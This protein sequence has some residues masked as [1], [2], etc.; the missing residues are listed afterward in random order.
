M[1]LTI[2]A[3]ILI[4]GVLVFV[5][6]LGHFLAAKRSGLTVHEFGFGF[7]PRVFGIRRG[8]T[9]YSINWIPIGGFVKIKGE[10]G[11]E[12]ASTDSFASLSWFR[13]VFILLSGV[14]MNI[15]LAAVLLS[16]G[17]AHGTPTALDGN[18]PKHAHV[19][20]KRIQVLSVLPSS[21]AGNLLEA[22]DQI[23]SIDGIA[24]S[25]IDEIQ[26]YNGSHADIEERVLVKRGSAEMSVTLIPKV[27]NDSEGRAV[28]GVSLVPTGIVAYPWYD[29]IWLG[30]K[31][32]VLLL[33]QILAAFWQLLKNLIVHQQLSADVAGPVGIAVLTGQIVDLGWMYVVE[34]TALLS[35][36]LA[37]VNALPFPALDGGRVLFVILEKVRGRKINAKA[38][39]VIHNVGFALLLVLVLVITLRDVNKLTGGI[40]IFFQR[41]F[42]GGGG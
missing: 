3:F 8:K 16:F 40:F 9:L 29:A 28:W 38:E 19:R 15:L 1:L 25:V 26:T 27:L 22:G 31:Q 4:L 35:L 7:P 5:H 17:F 18:L 42:G 36:N 21:P 24:V 37:L 11:D 10:N 34:F 30:A 32:S 13:R 2:I 20:D 39:S 14:A 12:Q 6:E 23:L 41:L 33:G